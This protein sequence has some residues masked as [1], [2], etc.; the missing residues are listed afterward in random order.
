[1]VE[2][3]ETGALAAPRREPGPAARDAGA[4]ALP[5]LAGQAPGPGSVWEH[6]CRSSAVKWRGPGARRSG[7]AVLH[8]HTCQLASVGSSVG[9]CAPHEAGIAALRREERANRVHM[10]CLQGVGVGSV[11]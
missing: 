10:L 6:D 3:G 8:T 1:M 5:G 2:R 7:A 9:S 4:G 11:F